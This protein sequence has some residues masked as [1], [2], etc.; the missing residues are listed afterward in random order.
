VHWPPFDF[1]PHELFTHVLGAM[2][3]LSDVQEDKQA[4]LPQRKG[5][6]DLSGGVTQL[7]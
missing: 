5:E 2:Q 1:L 4:P 7:P 3:S 6:Q